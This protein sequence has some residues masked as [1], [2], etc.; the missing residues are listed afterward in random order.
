[1]L[2]SIRSRIFP[3]RFQNI[4]ILEGCFGTRQRLGVRNAVPLWLLVPAND[5]TQPLWGRNRFNFI[6]RVARSSQP[7]AGGRN[8]VGI[9]SFRSPV[10]WMHFLPVMFHFQIAPWRIHPRDDTLA[11]CANG[12]HK[13]HF[14]DFSPCILYRV[15]YV[16]KE[17]FYRF[18]TKWRRRLV[19]AMQESDWQTGRL[20]HLLH[21]RLQKDPNRASLRKLCE[22][23]RG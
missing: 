12:R 18:S 4:A 15:S 11:W 17:R 1:M 16:G 14:P 9:D 5:L 21:P 10:K 23:R 20:P 13:S 22:R 3:S 2:G 19:C 6:P 7:W 8:P